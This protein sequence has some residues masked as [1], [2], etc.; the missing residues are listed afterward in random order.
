MMKYKDHIKVSEEITGEIA[1]G[2]EESVN[3]WIKNLSE[4]FSDTELNFIQLELNENDYLN[5]DK[6][7][8]S[9]RG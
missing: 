2:K 9:T 7:I 5:V 8:S 6:L 4:S 3:D 1:L